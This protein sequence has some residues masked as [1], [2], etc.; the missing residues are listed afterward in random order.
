MHAQGASSAS[1]AS[2]GPRRITAE[3]AFTIEVCIDSLESAKKFVTIDLPAVCAAEGHA[4]RLEICANLAVGGGTTPS[5][6]L[7]RAVKRELP[8]MP[9]MVRLLSLIGADALGT[10]ANMQIMIRPRIGDFLYSVDEIAVMREDIRAFKEIG[11]DGVVL[12]VLD[13]DGDVDTVQLRALVN[14]ALPLEVTFHRAFDVSRNAL[15]SLDQIRSV[16]GVTRVLTSGQGKTVSDSIPM[17]QAILQNARAKGG[18]IIVAGS[19]INAK[20]I[21]DFLWAIGMYHLHELHLSGGAWV[22]GEMSFRR[23]HMGMGANGANEWKVWKTNSEE[24]GY[25]GDISIEMWDRIIDILE[26]QG[27]DW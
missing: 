1:A 15:K 2:A 25:V 11:V 21:S 16:P 6:G 22:E 5:M 19:G 24:V 18:P 23:S 17:L 20:T 3:G 4:H 26:D 9:I 8:T 14:E 12:G 10:N 27:I 7:V 13:A